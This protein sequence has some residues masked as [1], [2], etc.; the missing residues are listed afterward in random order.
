MCMERPNTPIRKLNIFNYRSIKN[1]Y[2][3]PTYLEIFTRRFVEVK[4]N[5][6]HFSLSFKDY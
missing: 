4:I 3:D 5:R 2:V 6:L 1:N